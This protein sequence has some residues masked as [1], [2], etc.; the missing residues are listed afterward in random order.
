M[1]QRNNIKKASNIIKNDIKILKK[2]AQVIKNNSKNYYMSSKNNILRRKE[3]YDNIN[4]TYD[5]IEKELRYISNKNYKIK[6]GIRKNRNDIGDTKKYVRC[7]QYSLKI[8]IKAEI[9]KNVLNQTIK[10][11]YTIKSNL[12]IA[13][14]ELEK[15]KKELHADKNIITQI[16][17]DIYH[18]DICN[19]KK[20]F[21]KIIKVVVVTIDEYKSRKKAHSKK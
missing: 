4:K 14:N 1:E 9:F 20:K 16:S 2:Q 12:H 19:T 15:Y 11:V 10:K 13:K 8:A 17:N 5:N 7:N 6:K 21:K 3:I 18:I